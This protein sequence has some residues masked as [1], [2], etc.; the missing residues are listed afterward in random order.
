MKFTTIIGFV[1]C[2]GLGL[3]AGCLAVYYWPVIKQHLTV[4][5]PLYLTSNETLQSS[6]TTQPITS[7]SWT[8]LL[9]EKEQKVIADYQTPATNLN[10]MTAQ[11]LR[12]IKASSDENYQQALNSTNTVSHLDNLLV[13]ISGFIV[14][15]DFYDDKSVQHFFSSLLWCLFTF[16]ATTT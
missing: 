9:P 1:C 3:F 7:L 8:A 14:P 15:I 2:T 16:S 4:E 10:D 13:S 5:P 12:S 6:Y 11:V